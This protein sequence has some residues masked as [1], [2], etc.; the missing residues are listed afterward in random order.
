MNVIV[1][2]FLLSGDKFMHLRQ[3]GLNCRTCGLFTK[4]CERILKFKEAGDLNYICK[5]ELEKISFSHD[6]LYADSKDLAKRTVLDK[7]LKD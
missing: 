2:K 7:I 6:P 3:P 4:H 1:N 5:N